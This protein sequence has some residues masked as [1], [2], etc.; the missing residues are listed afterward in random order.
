MMWDKLSTHE[1]VKNLA[2]FVC[3][4]YNDG[5]TRVLELVKHLSQSEEKLQ[6]MLVEL[7]WLK[8]IEAEFVKE[9]AFFAKKNPRELTDFASQEKKQ[10]LLDLKAKYIAD[11]Q[12]QAQKAFNLGYTSVLKKNKIKT[13]EAENEDDDEEDRV[14]KVPTTD[15]TT[16]DKE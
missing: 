7:E 15:H 8:G 4:K 1:T 9:K 5:I 14:G 3:L 6:V 2:Q 11:M 16:V 13:S 12:T 10:A